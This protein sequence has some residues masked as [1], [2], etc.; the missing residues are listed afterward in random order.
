[1]AWNLHPSAAPAAEDWVATHALALLAGHTDRVVATLAALPT[2]RR[3]GIDACIRY[4]PC[5][6]SSPQASEETAPNP[7]L[8]WPRSAAPVRTRPA[9][10]PSR[11]RQRRKA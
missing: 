10:D 11:K 2:R 9:P 6:S 1:V 4:Q 7:G 8:R 5:P 3:D